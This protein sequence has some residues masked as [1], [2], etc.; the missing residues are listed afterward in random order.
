MKP[1]L[2]TQIG[3]LGSIAFALSLG[4]PAQA[5]TVS[6]R[7]IIYSSLSQ[8][9]TLEN[10]SSDRNNVESTILSEEQ[11]LDQKA[12]DKFGCDCNSCLNRILQQSLK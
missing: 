11:V 3:C 6:E 1:S 4:T 5:G 10:D 2:L 8:P 12:I 7:T 9:S